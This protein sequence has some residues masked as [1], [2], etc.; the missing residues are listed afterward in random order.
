MRTLLFILGVSLFAP[1]SSFAAKGKVLVVVSSQDKLTLRDGK[2]YPTGYYFNELTVPVRKLMENGYDVVFAN[3]KG[4]RPTMDVHSDSASYFGNDAGKYADFKKFHDGL[5]GLK[6][7][8]RL[9]EVVAGGLDGYSGIFVPG[10]HAPMEDLLKDADLGKALNHFHAQGKP[11]ALICHGPIAL[12]STVPDAGKFTAALAKGDK[13]ARKLAKGWP[14]AGYQLTIFSTAEEKVAE[15]GQLGGKMLFYP[16]AALATAG[17]KMKEAK[18][19]SNNVVID[20]E[21]ITGQNPSSDGDL[22]EAFLGAL[23]AKTL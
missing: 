17:G 18:E 5:A 14:Y 8:Q 20:R 2:T 7:P 15:K 9:S 11:T 19:W 21:L 3:P 10:G 22:A 4:N 23:N 1:L 6:A 12:L 16:D 13:G